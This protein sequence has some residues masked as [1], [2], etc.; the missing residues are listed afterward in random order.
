M[1]GATEPEDIIREFTEI[2]QSIMRSVTGKLLDQFRE[3][4]SRLVKV[5]PE[6]V[7]LENNPEY[8][9]G[10]SKGDSLVVLQFNLKLENMEGGLQI[11]IPLAGFEPVQTQF[12]PIEKVEHRSRDEVRRDRRQIMDLV[13]G[14][15]SEVVVRFG[16]MSVDLNKIMAIQEGDIIHLGQPVNAP[17][18]VEVAGKPMFLGEA[19]RVNQKRAVKLTERLSEE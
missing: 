12:D 6:F 2:E 4:C 18:I 3:A 11:G 14:T 7:A 17:L 16:E 19:G 8:I 10:V 9:T 15:R 13:Q 5:S 1:G